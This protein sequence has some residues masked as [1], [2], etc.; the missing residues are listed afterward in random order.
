MHDRKFKFEDG[1]A[2]EQMMGGWSQLVGFKFLQWLSPSI[3]Q[4]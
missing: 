4:R 3:E 2:Y 1:E